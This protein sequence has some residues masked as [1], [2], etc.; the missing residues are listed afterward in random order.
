MGEFF[1]TWFVHPLLNVLVAF[2]KLFEV[3]Q[4]PGTLGL[5]IIAFT[6]FIR[7]VMYPLYKKQ[8]DTTRKINE[9]KPHLDRLNEL[10]KEDKQK[11]QQ[12]QL[13]LYQE[14][15]VNPL[16]G[17][18]LAIVQI[19]IFIALYNALNYF[20]MNGQSGA[21]KI[22]EYLYS[23]DLHIRTIDTSFLGYNL[24][25]TPAEGGQWFYYLIPVVTGLLQY[26]QAATTMIPATPPAEKKE[27]PNAGT[28]KGKGGGKKKAKDS[29]EEVKKE[30]IVE[31]KS[32]TADEFQKA[33]QTQIK[34]MFPVMIGFFSFKFPVA[35]S[36]YWNVFSLFSIIQYYLSRNNE[37]KSK[38]KKSIK[39]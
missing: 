22:N 23:P 10:H 30:P 24:T 7:L 18:L 36:L 14:A 4:I 27:D 37:A 1:N 11:L 34:Y 20:V 39:N 32:D 33:M 12:E 2:Y 29:L 19:P 38:T 6:V 13:R 25:Q 17:C 21:A 26:F 3:L 8:M 28:M 9:L 16:A 35:L 15:G 5:A 31:K